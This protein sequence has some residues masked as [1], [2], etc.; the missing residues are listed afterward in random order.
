MCGKGIGSGKRALVCMKSA[1]RYAHKA[2]VSKNRV[3]LVNPEGL[4]WCQDF[5]LTG[6][7]SL[8]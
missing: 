2:V 6:V 3:L 5:G 1:S 7:F 8:L 4:A